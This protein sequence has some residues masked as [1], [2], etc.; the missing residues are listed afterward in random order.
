MARDFRAD[1]I[2]VNKI[3]ASGSSWPLATGRA[4]DTNGNPTP[5]EQYHPN[6][7]LLFYSSSAA[8]DYSG[9]IE[10][11][12][13]L[14][15]Q[16]GNEPWLVFSGSANNTALTPVGD[17]SAVLFL[18]D[19]IISGTLFGKRQLIQIDSDVPNDFYVQGNTHLSGNFFAG[20]TSYDNG[21]THTQNMTVYP[22]QRGDRGVKIN[23]DMIVYTRG[24]SAMPP[25][26]SFRT[27]TWEDRLTPATG[28]EHPDVFFHVS[29]T[30]GGRLG[31]QRGIALF[32]GDLHVSG[33]FSVDG[34]NDL[35]KFQ[36]DMI[37][38]NTRSMPPNFG[39][40]YTNPANLPPPLSRIKKL[41]RWTVG[42]FAPNASS[43][44]SVLHNS[45]STAVG[46]H[47]GWKLKVKG[48]APWN[49][50]EFTVS[51]SGDVGIDP[52]KTFW[53]DSRGATKTGIK[54][55][56]AVGSNK[57]QISGNIPTSY[58]FNH[59]V[60][61][62]SGGFHLPQGTSAEGRFG[63]SMGIMFRGEGSG[64]AG[65]EADIGIYYNGSVLTNPILGGTT[66]TLVFTG[67][68]AA[69]DGWMGVGGKLQLIAHGGLGKFQASTNMFLGTDS[70]DININPGGGNVV[71][72]D[73]TGA[74]V[75]DIDTSNEHLRLPSTADPDDYFQIAVGAAGTTT[76]KTFD[77]AAT[78]AHLTVNIDG[79]IAMNAADAST[80][81]L[82]NSNA[83]TGK[84]TIG[85]SVANRSEIELNATNI[86]VNA[87]SGGINLDAAGQSHLTTTAGTLTLDGAGGVNIVGNSSEV[88]IT[89][90]GGVDINS[91]AFDVDA[92]GA[93]ALDSDSTFNIGAT[94]F[95]VTADGGAGDGAI[96][97]QTTDTTN[98]VKICTVGGAS[99]V[100][101]QIG[102]ATSTVTI[103][104]DLSVGTNAHSGSVDV[105]GDLTVHGS[106]IKGHIIS[107]SVGDPLLLLNSGALSSNSGGGIAIASGS[108]QTNIAMVFGRDTS[109]VNTFLVG[110][111]D[112]GDGDSQSETKV[113]LSGATPIPIRTTGVRFPAGMALTS[114]QVTA[115]PYHL[116]MSNPSN[117]GGIRIRA[118]NPVVGV[119]QGPVQ[120]S[121]SMFSIQPDR[122]VYLLESDPGTHTGA[123]LKGN[124]SS[125]LITV[126]A[127][128]GVTIQGEKPELRLADTYKMLTC[129]GGGAGTA[130]LQLQN[131]GGD[132]HLSS[133]APG[134]AW[135][136][137][138]ISSSHDINIKAGL[139]SLL[140]VNT[141]G[142]FKVTGSTYS[143]QMAA[144]QKMYLD[145]GTDVS[146]QLDSNLLKINLGGAYTGLR[147]DD[148][149]HIY[150]DGSAKYVH[151]SGQV[152]DGA[153]TYQGTDI[154]VNASAD[155]IINAGGDHLQL[156]NRTYGKAVDLHAGSA[157]VWSAAGQNN[158][159]GAILVASSSATGLPDRGYLSLG[160]Q[161]GE[162]TNEV[163]Y[164][165]RHTDVAIW[166]S[167][168]MGGRGNAFPS[169]TAFGGDVVMS[170]S[171]SLAEYIYLEDSTATNIRFRSN[172]IDLSANSV[173]LISLQPTAGT[174]SIAI[175]G[176][177]GQFTTSIGGHGS[178]IFAAA[179]HDSTN[180]ALFFSDGTGEAAGLDVKFYVSGAAGSRNSSTRGT[181]VFGG[182]VHCSGS[183][184]TDTL[185]LDS[186]TL[187]A[188]NSKLGFYNASNFYIQ[189]SSADLVFKD[190][191][192]GTQKTL[193]QLASQAMTE[194]LFSVTQTAVGV[195]NYGMT[196]GS[197]S[198]DTG[199]GGPSA[200]NAR[201]TNAI[202]GDVYF[203]VS[204]TMG[205]KAL[206]PAATPNRGVSVFGGDMHVSGAI[207]SDN[208]A[209]GGSL[210][211]AYDMPNGG[212]TP[213]TGAGRSIT[214]NG[215]P[216]ALAN[217]ASLVTSD[218]LVVSGGIAMGQMRMV[219]MADTDSFYTKAGLFLT[220]SAGELSFGAGGAPSAAKTAFTINSN[221]NVMMQQ[222]S[223][224][225]KKLAFSPSE[226]ATYLQYTN[227]NGSNPGGRQLTMANQTTAGIIRLIAGNDNGV[228][229]PGTGT[230][231]DGVVHCTGSFLPGF[232]QEYNLGSATKRWANVYTGDLHLRNDRGNWTIY[233]E[234]DMLVVVN[235]LTGKKYKMGLTPLEDEE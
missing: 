42:Q 24:S 221:A 43:W 193:T 144:G 219:P 55:T 117:K 40:D 210:D 228:G 227:A 204:G 27:L 133:S 180:R 82:G 188:T 108:N 164:N 51:G 128:D 136:Q 192:L 48:G 52:G 74:A 32:G 73:A 135:T 195:P 1:Q 229:N 222:A 9:V 214:V 90:T 131:A 122:K 123:W 88:D 14:M 104:N 29:G 39:H 114:S 176:D 181:T 8:A 105:W 36:E 20:P 111:L 31:N 141:G 77:D 54:H 134:N 217:G 125:G 81:G 102:G 28:N 86:D 65:N 100:P 66:N 225:G 143:F 103:G 30:V 129:F 206:H 232:D 235:N 234:P 205:A 53:F 198:F 156:R 170:G 33:N 78:G 140:G 118:G 85:G 226:A 230:G 75:V 3:I 109:F 110:T 213:S 83:D 178:L 127:P 155:G 72:K 157:W 91:A 94:N 69:S 184:S 113:D 7:G 26:I 126:S 139:G 120:L 146:L 179:G 168:T 200:N 162:L 166:V 167:G 67:T 38:N 11:S 68:N 19:V 23:S 63:Q 71:F 37:L 47:G 80:I 187:D 177:Q 201:A 22:N 13:D 142:T 224:V 212:G 211:D 95:V 18:G 34:S 46:G 190:S 59:G 194:N 163:F 49:G 218:L 6:L 151:D 223:G 186:L 45:S 116:S 209:F 154:T 215:P 70:G 149:S 16:F 121:G 21:G 199:V 150:F 99:A 60:V 93:I 79:N 50:N 138:V 35:V 171:L 196:T 173:Q 183:L 147:L 124:S 10:G 152:S 153:L 89:T 231:F 169:V 44:W 161:R 203:F 92:S 87:G 25:R 56:W 84:I 97:L 112:V 5:A 160:S 216:V 107:A 41:D 58:E 175:N 174:P 132:L 64:L 101:I 172:R 189:K 130:N 208:T 12:T 137:T 76:I 57:L 2:R 98:G 148:A 17:G 159:S 185:S 115:G 202:G 15:N 158:R 106:F 182:D 62:G 61:T 233:E 119:N 197:F 145:E 207:T 4:V 191:N 220:S 96:S 165:G